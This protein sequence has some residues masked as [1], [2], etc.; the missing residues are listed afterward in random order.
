MYTAVLMMALT[1]GGDAVSC[2]R[3]CGGYSGC[4]GYSGCGYSGCGYSG[5]GYSGCGYSSCGYSGCGYSGCG[6]CGYSMAT[7]S[8]AYVAA[9]QAPATL[10]VSLPADAKLT[11]DDHVT[12]STSA[13]RTFVTPDLA[14]GQEYHYTLTAEVT[15]DGKPIVFSERVT[16]KAGES[17]RITLTPPTGV[18][19]R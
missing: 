17:S 12:T 1:T 6:S 9:A 15:V 8:G 2:G 4:C 16:V 7:G 5:C 18:A 10:I 3:G 14:A 11:I 19:S 13:Q